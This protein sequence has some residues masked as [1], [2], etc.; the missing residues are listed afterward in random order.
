MRCDFCQNPHRSAPC[1]P[2]GRNKGHKECEQG[3]T[4]G[5]LVEEVLVDDCKAVG[6]SGLEE[7]QCKVQSD[8]QMPPL[9]V[10]S[11]KMEGNIWNKSFTTTV[12]KNII[13]YDRNLYCIPTEIDE[14][15]IEVVVF[16]DVMVVEGSKKWELTLCGYFVG[17]KM[18]V[19]ELRY[20]LRR[21]WGRYGFKDIVDYNNEVFFMKFHHEEGLNQVVNSSEMEC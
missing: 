13:K 2:L 17:Y 19:N 1:L 16:Y 21:M 9:S 8:T 4:S 20:N 3:N 5:I 10:N 12:S 18:T 15:G 7:E 11:K 14:N 6:N